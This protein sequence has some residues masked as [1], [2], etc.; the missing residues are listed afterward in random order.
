MVSRQGDLSKLQKPH[1][2][3]R[4]FFLRVTKI[5]QHTSVSLKFLISIG[6]TLLLFFSFSL[7]CD[8]LITLMI[9]Y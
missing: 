3:L 4:L 1:A 9:N 6:R 5:L 7:N 2:F 8:L